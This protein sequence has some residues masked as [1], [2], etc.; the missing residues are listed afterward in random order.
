MLVKEVSNNLI[1]QKNKY[2]ELISENIDLQ[3][4][5]PEKQ[6]KFFS[7]KISNSISQMNSNTRT[8]FSLTKT[9]IANK[10][11]L[12]NPISTENRFFNKTNS[13]NQ[14]SF[15]QN[16][17]DSFKSY[18]T[19]SFIRKNPVPKNQSLFHSKV[20]YVEQKPENAREYV[21]DLDHLN[22]SHEMVAQIKEFEKMAMPNKGCKGI[23]V[24][25][26]YPIIGVILRT[27]LFL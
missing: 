6:S 4:F 18:K 11:H 22:C 17:Q 14:K 25:N 26:G 19:G 7:D 23:G 2:A 16:S 12:I 1:C 13:S 20:S 27:Y 24:F 8:T 21:D 15:R 10:N 5:I 3:H 9:G